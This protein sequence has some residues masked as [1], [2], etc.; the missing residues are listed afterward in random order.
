LTKKFKIIII[1]YPF[2][3]GGKME[4]EILRKAEE[5]ERTKKA[6]IERAWE[7]LEEFL[8]LFPFRKYPEKIDELTPKKIY[9]PGK[10]DSFLYWPEFGLKDLGRVG[11][12]NAFYAES[13][14]DNAEKFKELLRIV[15]NDSLSVSQKVDAPWE[16]IK[17]W[18]GDKTVAKK[19]IF[20]YYP[21][22]IL[23]IF[24][25]AELE[26][27]AKHFA[28]LLKIDIDFEKEA[29]DYYDKSYDL[30]SVGQK[31]ELLNELLMKYKGS[32]QVFKNWDNLLFAK[33]L[34]EHIPPEGIR[35][36]REIKPLHSLGILFEP[37]YEQ[38]IVYLFSVFHRKLGFPYIIKIRNE[39]PDALVMDEKREIKKIEFEVRASDFI[40]HAHDKKDCDVLICWEN[41]LEGNE[42][43]P[44]IIALKDFVEEYFVEELG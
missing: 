12:F 41:D 21:D 20:S 2:L 32:I 13:A 7:R 42:D 28:K 1:C 16:E 19:I 25:T 30:L 8:K 35:A 27:F 3:K 38:E 6:E 40:R 5:F 17:W 43:L 4:E 36:A 22:S 29:Y 9:T 15:V 11:G 37:E 23:P 44:L 14:R 33:F 10:K 34:Y 39:F 18:G 31:F 24:K 26:H